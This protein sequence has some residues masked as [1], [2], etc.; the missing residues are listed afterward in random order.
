[1][2]VSVKIGL[3]L[4]YKFLAV[5]LWNIYKMD[6]KR[7]MKEFIIFH[8]GDDSLEEYEDYLYGT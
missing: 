3:F 2:K 6:K 4:V 1:M 7:A 5:I 8:F